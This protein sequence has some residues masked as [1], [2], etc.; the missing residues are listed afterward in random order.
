MGMSRSQLRSSV[1]WE[2]VIVALIGTVIGTA[3]GVGM[4]YTMVK[5]LVSQGITEFAIPVGGMVT[6]VVFG[7]VLG[8]VAS[9]WPAYK[10]SK[11]NVLDAIATE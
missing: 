6:V 7:A 10:T 11:L 4:S 5:V 3:L 2:A 9:I 8:V 1:R